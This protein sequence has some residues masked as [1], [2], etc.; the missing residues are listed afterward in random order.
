MSEMHFLSF[1]GPEGAGKTTV[2]EAVRP[3]LAKLAQAD[4]LVTREPG[5]TPVAEG[6]R[7]LLQ[8]KTKPAM[9]PWTEALL[10]AAS[11]R[12]HLVQTVQ[13]AIA[14]GKVVLSDRYL[15]SS[16]A[17]QGG[18]R[19]LGVDRIAELNAF[20]TQGQLPDLTIYLDLPVEVGLER[21][22]A[23]RKGKID[24]LDEEE[25][26]FHQTVRQTYLELVEKSPERIKLVNANQ[27]VQAVIEE[28]KQV[29]ATYWR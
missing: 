29:L 7:T 12:E 22:F 27:D 28:V 14:A 1:E 21:I 4:V 17:Y 19:S 3:Y 16:L 13:P 26:S 11:R 18:G 24:R 23:N 15:D 20:A 5:G 2:I 9:D 10:Y 25:L 8:E 6:I